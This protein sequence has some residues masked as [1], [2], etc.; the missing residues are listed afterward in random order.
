V[1]GAGQGIGRSI[2]LRLA[3]DGYDLALVDL[4]S[5]S[6]KLDALVNEINKLGRKCSPITSDISNE[7]SVAAMV[8]QTVQDL[9]GLDVMVA[10]AGI[11]KTMSFLETELSDWE[12][13]FSVNARGTFLCYKYAAKQM[14][15]QGRGGRIIGASSIAG[16][17]G[18]GML[19]AYSA[20]KFAVRGIT[21]SAA[22]ELAPYNITV[23]TYAPGPMDTE[24]LTTIYSAL[25]D[26]ATLT[27]HAKKTTPVGRLGKPEDVASVVSFLASKESSYVTGQSVSVNGG[28]FFD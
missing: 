1:T 23:N 25:G 10:N 4:P 28:R 17:Q 19:G 11:C 7:A 5:N 9:G 3:A 8:A 16:K 2:A 22:V 24:M 15:L 26:L 12:D 21:Q 6:S 18:V 13:I 14:V 20:S 27:D